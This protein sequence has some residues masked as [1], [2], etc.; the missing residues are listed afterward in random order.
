MLLTHDY[1]MAVT[2][3]TASSAEAFA[4]AASSAQELLEDAVGRVGQLEHAERTETLTLEADG[5][6]YP[7][8][9]PLVDADAGW[10]VRDNALHGGSIDL[11][12][13]VGLLGTEYPTD[14]TV[15]YR[16]GY[17]TATLPE[18]AMR[19]LA[20][21]TYLLLHPMDLVAATAIPAGATSAS[22]GDVSL[23]FGPAGASGSIGRIGAQ[24]VFSAETL[25][26]AGVPAP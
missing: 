25:A 16:G 6:L 4:T 19:D 24:I 20:L 17:T 11:A 8:A 1:Y 10:Q 13:F 2:G 9:V 14:V 3:D 21:A 12:S 26:L 22:V 18:Y 7:R 23:S 5:Y 15:T